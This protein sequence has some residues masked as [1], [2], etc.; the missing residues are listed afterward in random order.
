MNELFLNAEPFMM[1]S[2][3]ELRFIASNQRQISYE[4]SIETIQ[5]PF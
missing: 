1:P 5:Q 4:G 3:V 2:E